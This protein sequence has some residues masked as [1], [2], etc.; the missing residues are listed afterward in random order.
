MA[1]KKRF[2]IMKKIAKHGRQAVIVVPSFL[3]DE[4]KPG[5]LTQLTIDVIDDSG[6]KD[7]FVQGGKK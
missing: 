3:L 6:E 4:L 2:I 7:K 5:T 1:R